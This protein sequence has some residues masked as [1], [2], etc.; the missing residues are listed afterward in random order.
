MPDARELRAALRTRT[1]LRRHRDRVIDAREVFGRSCTRVR[2]RRWPAGSQLREVRGFLVIEAG[3]GT[4]ALVGGVDFVGLERRIILELWLAFTASERVG[5]Q[6]ELRL[7]DLLARLEAGRD[8][9]EPLRH[10]RVLGDE[11]ADNPEHRIALLEVAE[12]RL[13][14]IEHRAAELG[15]G[16]QQI[17]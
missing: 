10:R 4:Q 16:R 1:L 3:C 2:L 9:R 14:D 8:P 12:Q 17:R 15:T 6:D 7:R 11:L 5:E 13:D